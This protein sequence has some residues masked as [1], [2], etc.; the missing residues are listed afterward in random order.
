MI[1]RQRQSTAYD[2]WIGRCEE[3]IKAFLLAS[4]IEVDTVAGEKA[5]NHTPSARKNHPSV[6]INKPSSRNDHPSARKS[7]NHPS[8]HISHCLSLCPLSMELFC[9]FYALFPD[10]LS[11]PE[12]QNW[13]DVITFQQ[14]E[15]TNQEKENLKPVQS[16]PTAFKEE[17][18]EE[19][20]MQETKKKNNRKK[21]ALLM[22]QL[23]DDMMFLDKIANHPALQKN[24]L[25]LKEE[26][27]KA[28]QKDIDKV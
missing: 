11:N 8:F 2:E 1:N 5:R 28:P 14:V 17:T 24:I 27:G 3:T 16:I 25:I 26:D 13:M 6:R 19:L 18:E 15:V 23:H 12:Y 4:N 22:G 9:I 10:I 21:T 7:K 20:Q